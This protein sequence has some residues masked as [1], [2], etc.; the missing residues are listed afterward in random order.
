MLAARLLAEK[1]CWVAKF[2]NPPEDAPGPDTQKTRQAGARGHDTKS[3]G[4]R[5]RGPGPNTKS[6]ERRAPTQRAPKSA[7]LRYRN[8]PGSR[9]TLHD[10]DRSPI[11]RAPGSPG[12]D[13]KTS[14]GP[15]AGLR[16][17]APAPTLRRSAGPR[18]KVN[19][20]GPRHRAPGPTERAPGDDRRVPTQRVLGPDRE[21]RAQ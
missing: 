16:Q 20:V 4:P 17:R 3:A 9:H 1:E 5:H 11:G 7:E 14:A 21:R 13:T 15:R 19:S 8:N 10:R 2:F 12:P 6:A 18:H